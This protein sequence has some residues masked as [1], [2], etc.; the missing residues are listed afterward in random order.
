M[1][2][3]NYGIFKLICFGC[4]SLLACMWPISFVDIMTKNWIVD[5]SGF[6]NEPENVTNNAGPALKKKKTG[7]VQNAS[8]FSEVAA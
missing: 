3:Y 1:P 5:T 6:V 2:D 7:V 4:N 8:V